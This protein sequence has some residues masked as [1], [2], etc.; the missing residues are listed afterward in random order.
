VATHVKVI[1]VLFFIW[2]GF[3]LLMSVFAGAL[4]SALAG[5]VGGT[6]EEG[7]A[8][9]AVVLG[10]TGAALTTFLVVF[11]L[12]HLI[13]GWGLLKFKRWAR[14]LAIVLAAVALI[15]IPFGTLFGIYALIILFRKDTEAL[16]QS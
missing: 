1:A 4:M 16:F 9:G 10:L 13:A 3:L 5:F 12:P 15:R 8:V 6:H 2:G 11:A 7:A 14:I